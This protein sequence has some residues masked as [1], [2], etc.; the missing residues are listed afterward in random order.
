MFLKAVLGLKYSPPRRSGAKR[1]EISDC[2]HAARR[3]SGE[4][5]KRLMKDLTPKNHAEAVAT[6]R[7]AVI[8]PLCARELSH[9]ELAEALREIA[10]TRVRPPGSG[11]T[12]TYSVPTLERWLYAYRQG[13]LAALQPHPRSDRGRGRHLTDEL[14]RLICDI[15]REH[16]TASARL[17]VRTLEADGRLPPDT[18]KPSTVRKL[19]RQQGLDRVAVRDGM[20]AK[21]RLRWQAAAPDALWHADVCHG[22][23]LHL[24]G[25]RTPIRIHGMLDD[26][27]RYVVALEAHASEREQDMLHVLTRALRLHGKPDVLFLDNGSTYR[28]EVLQTACSR[29][30]ISLV[31]AR[32]YD[33]EAR[34]KMERF[35]RTLREGCLD[36]LGQ[37][38]SLDDINQRLSVF[39]ARHYHPAPHAG[40]MGRAPLSAYA[41]AERAANHVTEAKLREAL[42][43]RE[44]RRVRRDTT[45]SVLGSIY[46]LQQ[47]FLAGKVVDVVYSWL[48]DPPHP[49]VEY[50]DKRYP[51]CL[52]DPVGN[53]RRVRSPRHPN[54]GEPSE[55]VIFDPS[56]INDADDDTQEADDENT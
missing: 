32:P 40:L 1:P 43:V 34:G 6:F 23:T 16:P 37:V 46:E 35:W 4:R 47:G 45:V 53:S 30:G 21:T 24:G 52:V 7:H 54:H 22:P 11:L 15:R 5:K 17:I 36:H 13:G 27:S 44:R 26:C 29:L 51:L 56:R 48:D 8:G 50:E 20:G 9:G 49:E 33:P 18:V 10:S 28:G 2:L 3:A 19:L 55:R 41:P 12:K 31:H 14:R 38:G 25:V 42:A 39:L